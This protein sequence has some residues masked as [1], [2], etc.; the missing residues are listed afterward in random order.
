MARSAFKLPTLYFCDIQAPRWL[1]ESQQT[2][3]F[4]LKFE[5][6]EMIE[7][8]RCYIVAEIGI[9]HTLFRRL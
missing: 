2:K 1:P 8:G 9:N 3:Q 6:S 7:K 4:N 5:S